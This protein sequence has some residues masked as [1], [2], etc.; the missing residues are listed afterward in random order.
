MRTKDSKTG[1]NIMSQPGI[2]NQHPLQDHSWADQP[3]INDVPW[4]T[5]FNGILTPLFSC[6]AT[7]P[8]STMTCYGMYCGIYHTC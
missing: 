8:D 5:L 1:Q 4:G 7:M 3:W 2:S 6:L